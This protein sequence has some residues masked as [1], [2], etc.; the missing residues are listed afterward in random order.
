MPTLAGS[1]DHRAL[2]SRLSKIVARALSLRDGA[3]TK[4][5][6]RF[7]RPQKGAG[8]QSGGMIVCKGPPNSKQNAAARQRM[9][10]RRL[11]PGRSAGKATIDG[12]IGPPTASL[13]SEKGLVVAPI[14]RRK[15]GLGV[16]GRPRLAGAA[17]RLCG[18]P[19]AAQGTISIAD[20][21][22]AADLGP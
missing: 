19:L 16:V 13:A 15:V 12:T 21:L 5:L 1:G 18:L 7:E 6:G 2:K 9:A 8:R 3:T 17:S 14:R 20:D 10:G 11:L 4:G 22:F